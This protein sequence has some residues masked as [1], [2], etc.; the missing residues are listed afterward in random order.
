[1]RTSEV[2]NGAEG[3]VE[4]ILLVEDEEEARTVLRQILAGKGYRVL[5]A[6]S[7]DEALAVAAECEERIDLLLTDVTMPRMKGPELA[8]RLLGQRPQLRVIYMSGY[9]EEPLL[10]GEDAPLC[11]QKPFSAQTLARAVRGVLDTPEGLAQAV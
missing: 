11:L 7:G 10:G 4:T 5:A 3:G 6:A 1:V 2:L 9:N 8:S